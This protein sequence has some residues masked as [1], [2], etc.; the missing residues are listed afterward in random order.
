MN[1]LQERREKFKT[2]DE[3]LVPKRKYG[4]N[5]AGLVRGIIINKDAAFATVKFPESGR[6]TQKIPYKQ[7]IAVPNPDEAQTILVD[8]SQPPPQRVLVVEAPAPTA[9]RAIP[10][11]FSLLTESNRLA[12]EPEKVSLVTANAEVAAWL[13]MGTQLRDQLNARIRDLKK[14]SK[15]LAAEAQA[16]LDKSDLQ[17]A[18]AIELERQLT[19]IDQ[20]RSLA[21][22]V[23][24]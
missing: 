24:L 17:F 18:E 14:A 19:A 12:H 5:E 4:A 3:V 15:D 8:V 22:N 2:G 20:L 23:V 9:L 6:A 13:D 7:L 11:A 10:T 16:L 1:S 21:K